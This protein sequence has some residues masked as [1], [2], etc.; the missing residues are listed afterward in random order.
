MVALV[1]RTIDPSVAADRV[2]LY[3]NWMLIIIDGVVRG[4]DSYE[5]VRNCNSVG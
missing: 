3:A 1:Q 4:S 5:C 2:Q